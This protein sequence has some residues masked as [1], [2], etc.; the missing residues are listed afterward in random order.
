MKGENR[1]LQMFTSSEIIFTI[2]Y[3]NLFAL[4]CQLPPPPHPTATHKCKFVTAHSDPDYAGR[5]LV[6]ASALLLS[7]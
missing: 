4:E 6:L 1:F 3:K 5:Q 2:N 7:T